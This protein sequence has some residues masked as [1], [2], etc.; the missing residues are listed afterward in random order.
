MCRMLGIAASSGV[1]PLWL[2]SFHELAVTGDVLKGMS[3]GH[4]DGWGV[5]GYLAHWAVY[6]GRSEKDA[7]QDIENFDASCKKAVNSNSKILI[8]HLRKASKGEK[9]I[10]NSHPFIHKD[11]IFCHNGDVHGSEKLAVPGVEYEGS[12]DS[13]RFFRYISARLEHGIQKNYPEILAEAIKEVKKKC[14]YSSLTF[15]LS[16]GE[17]LVGYRD[18]TEDGKYFSLYYAKSD[19][20]FLLC[21]EPLPGFEWKPMKNG[22]MII[23]NKAGVI[24]DSAGGFQAAR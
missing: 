14:S 22:E 11:L 6:F 5:A 3:K 20:A 18:Y 24:I 2:E 23:V 1:S 8:A 4:D 10:G 16:N 13:E 7:S 15:L 19:R 21:S 9:H 17:R 12:T